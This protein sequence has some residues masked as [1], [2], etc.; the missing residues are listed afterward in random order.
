MIELNFDSAKTEIEVIKF[1][2]QQNIKTQ[3][4]FGT[5]IEFNDKESLNLFKLVFDNIIEFSD[6]HWHISKDWSS[7]NPK[8]SIY[9]SA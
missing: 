8:V 3:E 4:Y 6:K 5:Y 7:K 9:E 2:I 1:C